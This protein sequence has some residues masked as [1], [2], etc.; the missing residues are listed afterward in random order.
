MSVTFPP[1]L[2]LLRSLLDGMNFRRWPSGRSE[3]SPECTVLFQI[4]CRAKAVTPRKSASHQMCAA[5]TL[6]SQVA[7]SLQF[8]LVPGGNGKGAKDEFSIVFPEFV[9]D[10]HRQWQT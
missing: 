10:R 5:E 1:P 2:W 9:S 8:S 6:R 7:F 3:V 4:A